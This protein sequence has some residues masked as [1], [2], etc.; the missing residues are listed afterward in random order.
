MNSNSPDV[1]PDVFASLKWGYFFLL[2]VS[3]QLAEW[4][5]THLQPS[6]VG[7]VSEIHVQLHPPG[8]VR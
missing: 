5:H 6:G 2:P 1:S 7:L 4:S 8:Q 3:R